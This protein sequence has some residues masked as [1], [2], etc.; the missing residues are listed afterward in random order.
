MTGEQTIGGGSPRKGD[1]RMEP[2]RDIIRRVNADRAFLTDKGDLFANLYDRVMGCDREKELNILELGVHRGGSLLVWKEAFPNSRV[3]GLDSNPSSRRV[4]GRER[5]SVTIG[6]QDDPASLAEVLGKMGGRVDVVI[7]D[8]SHLGGPSRAS[9]RALFP[10][11][12]ADGWYVIEDWG[13][14]Y[15][16]DWPDG[17]EPVPG[18]DHT[19]GMVGLIKEIIDGELRTGAIR[20]MLLVRSICFMRKSGGDLNSW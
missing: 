9:F 12:S 6:S 2:I 3:F 15:R 8:C 14:G 16:P 18:V 5:I 1:T 20:E 11:L 4:E 10:V 19:A 7:D 13:V 17:A